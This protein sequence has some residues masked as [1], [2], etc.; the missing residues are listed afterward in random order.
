MRGAQMSRAE[1]KAFMRRRNGPALVRLALW[2]VMLACTSTLI[3]LSIDTLW[4]W[5]AMFVQG[6]VLVHHFSLQH[7]CTHYTAFRTRWLNDLVGWLCGISIGLAPRFFRYEHC[8]H[9]TFTQ[10]TGR[11]PE[12][13]TVPANAREYLLYLSAMP[14]W[15]TKLKELLRHASGHIT[16]AEAVFVPEV[17]HSRVYLEARVLVAIYGAVIAAMIT[18][19]WWAPLVYWVVPLLLGEPV[20]RFIRMT[21]HVACPQVTDMRV[22]TRTNRVG[23][24]WRFLGWNMNYHAEHHFAA[25]VPFHALPALHARLDGVLNVGTGGYPG[26]H[27]E[28]VAAMRRAEEPV[29]A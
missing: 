24:L 26:A 6:V 22:N 10:T 16:E 5:P 20:M 1:L 21:E 17:E 25:S 2:L 15:W 27:R 4:L 28:I 13:L 3:A 29:R 11:D 7:E 18:F 9:H 19:Q 14:Y 12:M 8:D 23:P